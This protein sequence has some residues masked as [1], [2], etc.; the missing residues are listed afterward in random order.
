MVIDPLIFVTQSTEK[1][2]NEEPKFLVSSSE[3]DGVEFI[4]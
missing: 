1:A 2:L 3:P 4:E